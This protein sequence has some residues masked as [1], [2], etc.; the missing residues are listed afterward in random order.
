[1]LSSSE[2]CLDVLVLN[3]ELSEVSQL[4]IE[5]VD[6]LCKSSIHLLILSNL[7]IG[8]IQVDRKLVDLNPKVL[9]LAQEVS[10]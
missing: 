2:S 8:C 7:S 1:M 6:L 4:S 5:L 9:D 3:S 10:L